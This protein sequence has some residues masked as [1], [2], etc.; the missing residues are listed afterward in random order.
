MK[1]ALRGL[2]WLLVLVGIIVLTSFTIDA[3]DTLRGSS[4]A[5]SGLL[6]N[7]T[8]PQCPEGTVRLELAEGTY[9]I[10]QYENSVGVNCPIKN[11]KTALDTKQNID[12]SACQ[13]VTQS[14]QTPWTSVTLT[15][16]KSLCI[17]REMR[18]P[19]PL[20]W[21]EAALG[22]P[23]DERCNINSGGAQTG[24]RSECV[25]HRGVNDMVGNVWEWVE[26]VVINGQ[27]EN[28]SLPEE[29]YVAG[30]AADGLANAT[31]NTPR[32]LYD[33]A[34]FWIG[35]EGEYA[36]MRGGYYGSGDDASVYTTHAKVAPDFHSTA[37]SFRCLMKL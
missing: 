4:T 18:L 36:L 20:E 13:A 29:G 9:C 19:T 30:S 10:D 23:A 28:R 1:L 11:P 3:T 5:L 37:I 14:D 21:Y 35:S 26:A 25:S 16:A 6:K 33:N 2:R 7:A 32:A 12:A 17:K 34:Y 24:V 22:T 15:Q 31:A 8:T 27:Y